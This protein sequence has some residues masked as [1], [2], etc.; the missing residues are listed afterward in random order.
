MCLVY[1]SHYTVVDYKRAEKACFQ[2]VFRFFFEV[3]H[4]KN[5][6]DAAPLCIIH[7]TVVYNTQLKPTF[8][9]SVSDGMYV[10]TACWHH[11]CVQFAN[12]QLCVG[13][14]GLDMN[15]DY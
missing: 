7:S 3:N 11:E 9:F 15:A 13:I 14:S 5:V 10:R 6:L 12:R 1:I 2:P 4:F 8:R